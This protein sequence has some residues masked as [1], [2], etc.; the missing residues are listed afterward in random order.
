MAAPLAVAPGARSRCAGLAGSR[1][2]R[3]MACLA[4]AR[5]CTDTGCIASPRRATP[6]R[7]MPGHDCHLPLGSLP[8]GTFGRC[9]HWVDLDDGC[10]LESY[11]GANWWNVLSRRRVACGRP[12]AHLQRLSG[13]EARVLSA[14][15]STTPPRRA[16]DPVPGRIPNCSCSGTALLRRRR[17]L[18]RVGLH[19]LDTANMSAS[20]CT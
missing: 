4:R 17:R 8:G 15:G 10:H 19:P 5:P 7:W 20:A 14:D 11:D 3:D 1:T 16:S 18:I 12:S 9:H 6:G 13:W 2:A